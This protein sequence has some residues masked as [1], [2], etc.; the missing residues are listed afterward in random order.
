MAPE[1]TIG[2]HGAG[3]RELRKQPKSIQASFFRIDKMIVDKGLK[4]IS[5]KYVKPVRGKIWE[6]RLR[7]DDTIARALYF[8]MK[9]KRVIVLHVFTKKT[10][11]IPN[12]H[13]EIA[14]KRAKE[15]DDG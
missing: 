5:S 8:T 2:F 1:W 6:M 12:R 9:G 13:I 11:Q 10:Q 7:G 3:K 15:V 14:L 4:T